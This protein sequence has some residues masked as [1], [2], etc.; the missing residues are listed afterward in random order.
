M[1]SLM[2]FFTVVAGLLFSVAC[3][4]LVEEWIFGGLFRAFFAPRAINVEESRGSEVR[5]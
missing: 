5:R 4:V 2:A 3:A 1:E